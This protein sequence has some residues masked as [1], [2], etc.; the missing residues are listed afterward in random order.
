MIENFNKLNLTWKLEHNRFSD[1]HEDEFEDLYDAANETFAYNVT[2][3]VHPLV[4]S[5]RTSVPF[6]WRDHGAVT[7]VKN[8]PT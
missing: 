7:S 6:D 8:A 4:L 3:E 2:Q 1:W 5:S